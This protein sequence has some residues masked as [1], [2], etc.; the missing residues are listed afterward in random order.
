MSNDARPPNA[1]S[2]SLFL[3]L[4]VD[5]CAVVL[6]LVLVLVLAVVLAVVVIVVFVVPVVFDCKAS[7]SA[8]SAVCF[9]AEALIASPTTTSFTAS[10]SPCDKSST[11]KTGGCGNPS[12]PN[13]KNASK[14]AAVK[15][16]IPPNFKDFNFPL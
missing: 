14:P 11:L 1:D 2:S 13:V 8:I 12:I 9:N 10:K 6:V 16:L 7:Q 3:A 5:V 15:F 4:N